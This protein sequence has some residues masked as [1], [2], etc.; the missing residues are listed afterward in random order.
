MRILEKSE[1]IPLHSHGRSQCCSS[2]TCS[3][4]RE[5]ILFFFANCWNW[6][7]Y[8]ASYPSIIILHLSLFLKSFLSSFR[9]LNSTFMMGNA[10]RKISNSDAIKKKKDVREFTSHQYGQSWLIVSATC[11]MPRRKIKCSRY[12][13]EFK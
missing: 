4:E 8:G 10:M 5:N 13:G 7:P 6:T 1:F 12:E 11:H 3:I 9:F 2:L